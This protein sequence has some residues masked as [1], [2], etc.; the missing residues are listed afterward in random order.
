[1]YVYD[2]VAYIQSVLNLS[3]LKCAMGREDKTYHDP[4]IV[5]CLFG[6]P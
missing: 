5:D 4:I 3:K 6:L 1:M 2:V